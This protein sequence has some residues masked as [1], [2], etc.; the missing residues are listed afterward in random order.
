MVEHPLM[1]LWII[2]S[3]LHG[4]PIGISLMVIE[5]YKPPYHVREQTIRGL[6]IPNKL[7]APIGIAFMI[8]ETYK[9]PC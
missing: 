1:M 6:G 2:G 3:I 7:K 4:G 8:I 5:T 9:P